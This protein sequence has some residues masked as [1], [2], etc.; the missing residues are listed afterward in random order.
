MWAVM[1]N[2]CKTGRSA[3]YR[4]KQ[5]ITGCERYQCKKQ[6]RLN[7]EKHKAA[8]ACLPVTEGDRQAGEDVVAMLGN[9]FGDQ[10]QT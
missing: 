10:R 4:L 8:R 3:A 9:I 5:D 1:T 2:C 7:Q 6:Q